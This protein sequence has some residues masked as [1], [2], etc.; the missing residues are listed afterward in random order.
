MLPKLRCLIQQI[1]SAMWIK[2]PSRLAKLPAA[3][4]IGETLIL[5][6]L[7]VV[8]TCSVISPPV[9]AQQGEVRGVGVRIK[10]QTGGEIDLYQGS[11]ALLIGVSKYTDGWRE[12]K[13]VTRDLDD[14][15]AVLRMHGFYVETLPNP[16]RVKFDEVVRKFIG[17]YGQTPGNRLIFYYAGHGYTLKTSDGRN[18]GYLVPSDAPLPSQGVGAFKERAISMSEIETYAN[19]IEAKHALFVFDSCF[20]GALFDIRGSASDAIT[21]KIADP[22]RE[23]ITAG[24][25]EQTV[26]DYSI[27]RQEFIAALNGEADFNHDG[28][29]TGAE[30]GEFL[31]VKV[32]NYTGGAQTPRYGKIRD[33]NLDRG[34]FVFA[35]PANVVAA[36]SAIQQPATQLGPLSEEAAFEQVFWAK[37]KDSQNAEDF[38]TY[39]RLYPNGAHAGTARTRADT[40]A[41]AP[42]H[43][44]ILTPSSKS[45][46]V[47]KR[48]HAKE[49]SRQ[50]SQVMK[51][52]D[53][54]DKMTVAGN[55]G[56][57]ET[58]YRSAWFLEP[59]NPVVVVKLA[60]TLASQKKWPEV[61]AQYRS[62]LQIQPANA[63]W[64]Y[65]LGYALSEQKRLGEAEAEYRAAIQLNQSVAYWHFQL[66]LLLSTKEEWAEAES[67]YRGAVVTDPDVAFYRVTL[68]GVLEKQQKVEAA[69][70]S[71]RQAIWVAAAKPE[72]QSWP[73][74][75]VAD[76]RMMLGRMLYG[77]KR[78]AEMN[79]EFREALKLDPTADRYLEAALYAFNIQDMPGA[80]ALYRDEIR[81]AP[82]RYVGHYWLG[83]TLLAQNKWADAEAA[84][85][86]A[87]EL[88]PDDTDSYYRLGLALAG[89]Q[90]WSDAES[91]FRQASVRQPQNDEY[92]YRIGLCLSKQAKHREAEQEYRQAIAVQPA[93][94]Y[95]RYI[96]G[97][98]LEAEGRTGQ[99][100]QEFRQ[101]VTLEPGN[102]YYH[103]RLGRTLLAL[104]DL[105]DAEAQFGEA[106]RLDPSQQSYRQE[107]NYTSL[108]R[109]NAAPK[110]R[111]TRR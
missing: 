32:A 22:V 83:H 37:I 89:Q 103:Y 9:Q 110:A 6:I 104:N 111:R 7:A 57:A 101:A 11:Y 71:Y 94:A 18:L 84:F 38:R 66:G 42:I 15:A 35:L 88:K 58:A 86:R 80:E 54:G 3:L 51:L 90:K 105:P 85:R 29:I 53:A 27:F 24:T 67:A 109:R 41:A 62:L 34:D 56:G 70:E 73:G 44:R 17:R 64:H 61:E 4:S 30:L 55:I 77:Q 33:P 21:A 65:E 87:I 60:Q 50:G 91:A 106:V 14:V 36:G 92:H 45:K 28:Y 79:T 97:E 108:R 69:I 13:G 8:T 76:Y 72:K 63:Q 1:R 93:S 40:T 98:A 31:S 48:D 81:L 16:T 68:A 99:A 75:K 82:D 39:L 49:P 46:S 43:G 47:R 59:S 10:T 23:F 74:L 5:L 25:A 52:I 19:E 96:L 95:W 20:S 78:F 102:A 26:P 2:F 100:E 12:L 107:L